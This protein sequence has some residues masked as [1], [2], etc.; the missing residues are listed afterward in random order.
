[1]KRKV[2]KF[3]LNGRCLIMRK[4]LAVVRIVAKCVTSKEE[5]MKFEQEMGAK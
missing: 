5:L 2:Y 1:M 4:L 3:N